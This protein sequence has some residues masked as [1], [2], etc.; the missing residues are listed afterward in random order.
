MRLAIQRNGSLISVFKDFN[1]IKDRGEI[2][3][4]ITE[5]ELLKLDLLA[6]YEETQWDLKH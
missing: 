6:L 1:D 4:I 3:Q 2:T 5:L